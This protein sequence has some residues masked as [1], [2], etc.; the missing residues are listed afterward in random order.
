MND[1]GLRSM[2]R[3]QSLVPL[4]AAFL[5]LLVCV[6]GLVAG[7]AQ[8]DEKEEREVVDKIPK[9]LPIKVKVKKEKEEKVKDLKN[10]D[11]LGDLELE[12][13]NTGTK[14]IYYLDIV[15]FMPDDFAPDGVNLGCFL[16][17]GRVELV[18]FGAP[19]R[20]DDVPIKPGEVAVLTV[21]ANLV[22]G[23]KHGRAKGELTNPRKIE[24]LF[25]LINFGDGTGFGGTT[26]API[27]D[28]KERSAN[29]TCAGGDS[30][31][32]AASV[33]DPPRYRFPKLA[34][35]ETFLPRPVSLTPAFFIPEGSLPEPGAAQD[36]CCASGCSRLRAAQDQG[37]P[38]PGVT[39]NIVQHT[40]CS[41]PAGL[42]GTVRFVKMPTC[43]AGGIEYYC[44]ESF[45]D[46]TC[47]AAPTP[48]PT[49]CTPTTPR[50]APCC[51]S[52][53]YNVPGASQQYCRWACTNTTSSC[54]T[55][56]VFADGC[57]SVRNDAP[58]I[59]PAGFTPYFSETYGNACCPAPPTPTPTPAPRT[60]QECIA[61]GGAYWSFMYSKCYWGPPP[62]PW[63]ISQGGG[64]GCIWKPYEC[65][66]VCTTS[67]V[68]IDV[69]GDGFSLTDAAGG[70]NFDLDSDGAAERLS[71]TAAGSDDAWLALD[72]N[73]NGV[74]DD[75]AELF[76]DITPQPESAEPNGFL[77]LA[78]FDKPAAGGNGDGVID[79]RDAVYASLRLWRDEN[80][81]GV[82]QAAELYALDALDV[83]RIHLDYKESRRADE[84]GNRFRYRA[85]VDDAKGA[86]AGRWAWDVFLLSKP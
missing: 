4:T 30:A 44:E 86:K 67:P 36:L 84:Y 7:G 28:I 25:G 64:S 55:G 35:L 6:C 69:K 47:N 79:S 17:Y 26:G 81:D 57:Y 5:L 61:A 54:G 27:P 50:P 29:A 85:K 75:G 14:P 18:D 48:T 56:T 9:H 24:F 20:P 49:P 63:P 70:V 60:Q 72:R 59:C 22:E 37:C 19:V 13:T 15:L 10:E 53:E 71:W 39:R 40:S 66:Y 8:S 78:E 34:S 38:C 51:D 2:F 12:V 68:L 33:K 42:C 83:A 62:C 41:D 77:A 80:H 23:W 74:I 3:R 32:E 21:P 31:G 45:R 11:W 43:I 82:S 16:K 52:G 1:Y 73:G 76:G 58:V 46:T 65:Q